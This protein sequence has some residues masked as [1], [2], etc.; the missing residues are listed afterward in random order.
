MLLL[1]AVGEVGDKW[2][3]FI[4]YLSGKMQLST[5]FLN[6]SFEVGMM[7]VLLTHPHFLEVNILIT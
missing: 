7:T 6:G 1:R 5:T 2:L 4:T 3:Q